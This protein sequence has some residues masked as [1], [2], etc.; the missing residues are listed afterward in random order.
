MGTL[1]VGVISTVMN[2]EI[3][4]DL[5]FHLTGSVAREH[6]SEPGIQMGRSEQWASLKKRYRRGQLVVA[7]VIQN[8]KS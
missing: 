4:V 6:A 7:A 2:D 8:G 5:P 1:V 3:E